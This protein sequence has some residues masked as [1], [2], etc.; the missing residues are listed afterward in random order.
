M[1]GE[2]PI[3][4]QLGKGTINQIADNA[5]ATADRVKAL[6]ARITAGQSERIA[7]KVAATLAPDVIESMQQPKIGVDGYDPP[8]PP[9]EIKIDLETLRLR[10]QTDI[11]LS[12]II[13]ANDPPFLFI[14]AGCLAQIVRDED[15]RPA[16]RTLDLD[17]LR[18][19]IERT[20]TFTAK[21]GK[22]VAPPQDVVHDLNALPTWGF[23]PLRDIS[24]A[25]CILPDG[26]LI[27]P[28]YCKEMR[29]YY[30]AGDLVLGDVPERPTPADVKTA[31]SL[32]QEVIIDFP[33]DSDAS[34]SNMI[35]AI[36][37]AILRPIIAGPVPMPLLDKPQLGT[38]AT[39]LAETLN[40]IATGKA[41]NLTTAP[42]DEA[43]WRKIVVSFVMQG[44]SII[45]LDDIDRKL[46]SSALSSVLTSS[47]IADR[48]LGSNNVIEM[49]QRTM[50]IATGNNI[51][52]GGD[53]VRRCYW[54][55]LISGEARP[56]LRQGFKHPELLP[57]VKTERGRILAAVLT[58]ARAWMQAG[59]PQPK[60]IRLG[61]YE[62]WNNIIGGMMEWLKA[63]SPAFLG[64]LEELY[65]QLDP[66][67]E[68]WQAF[69]EAIFRYH[70]EG[71]T[72][73][74]LSLMEDVIPESVKGRA[75]RV[76]LARAIGTAL[77]YKKDRVFRNPAGDGGYILKKKAEETGNRGVIWQ[78][79]KLIPG[80]SRK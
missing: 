14:K 16:I 5:L 31:I 51:Q 36:L 39:L 40:M 4:D 54:I 53:L 26:S 48:K 3:Q 71:V 29:T 34:R 20:S 7:G 75:E 22:I 59:S 1:S 67:A 58:L 10:D 68:E 13:K 57:W 80:G 17:G 18:C 11:A 73:K 43:E 21:K 70:P 60:G 45:I 41:A 38:G 6:G 76:G 24:E 55:R 78:V 72:V 63:Y 27:K 30:E 64:N 33:F 9:Q 46:Q 32:L 2:A 12:N 49:Y 62:A 37:T 56:W 42:T 69:V 79:V 74:D 77:R 50:W 19:I 15:G 25:P 23:P 52:L 47:G 28:G 66:D 8:Q 44:R 61:K 65:E 35:G